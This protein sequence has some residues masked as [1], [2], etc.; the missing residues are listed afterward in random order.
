MSVCGGVDVSK[1]T[2]EWTVGEA[3]AIQSVPNTPPGILCLVRGMQG[4]VLETIVVEA[5]GGYERALVDALQAAALPVVVVNPLRVRRLGEALGILAKTDP[6]DAR[7]LVLF[8]N[9]VKPTRRAIPGPTQRLLASYASRRR[10]LIAVV[11]AEKARLDTANSWMRRD[12]AVHV[13]M[14]EKRIAR[15]D[16]LIDAA[17]AKNETMQAQRTLLEGVPG[18]GP[19]IARTLL[20][21]LPELGSLSNRQIA[22]LVGLAPFA[23]D[24]GKKRGTRTVRGG[25][26]A[27]RTALYLGA[28]T[29]SRFNP[30]LKAQYDRL[31]D[32]GK[33]PKLA[34]VAVA[35]KLLTILNAMLRDGQPWQCATR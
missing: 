6:I 15:I 7:L 28:M 8:A 19:G 17:I 20:I 32:T 14:L 27:P 5:T 23:R 12:I 26:A 25:R 1:S 24:S 16:R 33:P 9:R 13:R 10:Q 34:F 30:V 11:V 2:L 3:G 29:G 22:S 18:V 21:D 31:R 35:R 4:V